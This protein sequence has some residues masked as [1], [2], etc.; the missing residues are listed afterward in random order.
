MQALVLY[1]LSPVPVNRKLAPAF[2]RPCPPCMRSDPLMV[3]LAGPVVKCEM[4]MLELVVSVGCFAFNAAAM[5]PTPVKV[6]VLDA[7]IVDAATDAT[8][9][10]L[11][12]VNVACFCDRVLAKSVPAKYRGPARIMLE[13]TTTEPPMSREG[14]LTAQLNVALLL[15]I[16]SRSTPPES[17]KRSV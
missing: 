12:V 5:S 1:I 10:A 6:M 8:L 3:L 15:V 16:P 9:T 11:L 14:A 2:S 13:P 7:L 4:A 17:P